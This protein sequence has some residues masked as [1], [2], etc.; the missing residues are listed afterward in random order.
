MNMAQN[1]GTIP[2]GDISF[3]QYLPHFLPVF[4][5]LRVV[6]LMSTRILLHLVENPTDEGVM[7]AIEALERLYEAS[8]RTIQNLQPL[9][10]SVEAFLAVFPIG[11]TFTQLYTLTQHMLDMETLTNELRE[12]LQRVR[13]ELNNLGEFGED[14]G[15]RELER[16]ADLLSETVAHLQL[17]LLEYDEV[18]LE[19]IFLLFQNNGGLF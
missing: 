8:A 4:V 3:F 1:T 14:V 16:G 2:F 11:A 10:D 15:L 18:L 19:G 13:T 7:G 6:L 5:G 9:V 12:T 17:Q